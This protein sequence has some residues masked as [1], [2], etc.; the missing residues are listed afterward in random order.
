MQPTALNTYCNQTKFDLPTTLN[1]K[2]SLGAC[3]LDLVSGI[4]TCTAPD[5]TNPTSSSP[6][7]MYHD[8][9][10]LYG[11]TFKNYLKFNFLTLL[12]GDAYIYEDK[13]EFGSII[14]KMSVRLYDTPQPNDF[15]Y[16]LSLTQ[17]LNNTILF[18]LA[19]T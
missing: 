13:S 11:A 12:L 16:A 1:K 14:G 3:S 6:I 15:V 19:A 9:A 8:T 18:D 5:P 4:A 10:T 17:V 7:P 2:S